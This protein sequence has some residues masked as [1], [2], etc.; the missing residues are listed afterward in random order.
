ML[1]RPLSPQEL[2]AA[3]RLAREVFLEFV[4]PDYSEEGRRSFLKFLEMEQILPLACLL[5]T[6]RCV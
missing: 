5:Y 1:V 2:P 6:S 3:M 4:A